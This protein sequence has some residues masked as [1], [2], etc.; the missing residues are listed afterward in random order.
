M[1]VDSVRVAT[2]NQ[3][4]NNLNQFRSDIYGIS[5][6]SPYTEKIRRIADLPLCASVVQVHF[7]LLFYRKKCV[8]HIYNYHTILI[9]QNEIY[10][11]IY[12]LFNCI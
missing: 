6:R 4:L 3:K 9:R 7:Q 2:K 11:S 12:Y 5:V 8:F 1:D 10:L